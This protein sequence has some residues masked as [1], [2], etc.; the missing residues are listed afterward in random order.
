MSLGLGEGPGNTA[1]FSLWLRGSPEEQG[2]VP[3]AA[4]LRGTRNPWPQKGA[5]R[6]IPGNSVP[7]L[8]SGSL[9]AVVAGRQSEDTHW[10][11]APGWQGSENKGQSCF[12]QA[13]PTR[14]AAPA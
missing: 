11:P 5:S 9:P 2:P 12:P 3:V 7:G 6:L 10:I 8:P 13:P 1:L 14:A 4:G